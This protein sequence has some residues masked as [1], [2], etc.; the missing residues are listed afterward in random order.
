MEKN[1]NKQE[2]IKIA[3]ENLKKVRIQ[4]GLTQKELSEKVGVS[5]SSIAKYEAGTRIC[6]PDVLANICKTL[7]IT[8]VEIQSTSD[9]T[10]N[11]MDSPYLSERIM[12][13]RKLAGLTTEMLAEQSGISSSAINRME[14]SD[15]VLKNI[16]TS[17][18]LKICEC[19][20]ITDI[21]SFIDNTK[22][23]TS[24]EKELQYNSWYEGNF[25]E[26]HNKIVDTKPLLIKPTFID[27]VLETL[28]KHFDEYTEKYT[29]RIQGLKQSRLI[30]F[31]NIPDKFFA[32]KNGIYFNNNMLS[33]L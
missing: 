28:D 12:L 22:I 15:E 32:K 11:Y 26:I 23:K 17:K 10:I 9:L 21:D 1:A 16:S 25:E 13:A 7:K 27:R 5:A 6:P 3:G 33:L 19:L 30:V 31:S 20:K 4:K 18:F 29:S 8:E 14:N 24:L 2:I